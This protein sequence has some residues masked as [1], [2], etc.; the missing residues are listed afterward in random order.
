MHPPY[1]QT[2]Q[3]RVLAYGGVGALIALLFALVWWP[4]LLLVLGLY[5]MNFW[6]TAQGLTATG[7]DTRRARHHAVYLTLSKFPNILGMALF[8]WRR[9]KGRRMQIIEYK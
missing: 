7:M 6:R 4:G 2:E 5:G 9:L 1:F 3:R 8:H